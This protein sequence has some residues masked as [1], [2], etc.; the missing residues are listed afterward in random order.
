MTD[1]IKVYVI[2]KGRY[3]AGGSIYEILS[4]APHTY[5]AVGNLKL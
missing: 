4:R 5:G 3:V 1:E 2:N